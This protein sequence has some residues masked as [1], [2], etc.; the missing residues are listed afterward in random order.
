MASKNVTYG[1]WHRYRWLSL[2][3]IAAGL[4]ISSAVCI[5]ALRQN[6]LTMTNLRQAVYDA[7]QVDGDVTT[8]LNDLRQFVYGH[9]NT[10][11]RLGDSTEPPIQLVNEFNRAVAAEQA[12]IATLTGAANQVYVDAQRQCEVASIPL[13]VRAQ[14]IQDYVSTHSTNVP[15]MNLPPKE[16]YTF[17]FASP[18]W[19]PDLAGWSML[20]AI[21]FGI[22][23]II[24][25][26]LGLFINRYL[27]E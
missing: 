27:K 18:T 6:N 10:D 16:V 14:C 23:L 21:G 3:V 7:D 25:L 5:Y 22:I 26:I 4:I 2:V 1:K 17:D 20:A 13:T 8:A 24:R 12:R 19:S 9:M 11:L 15:Q